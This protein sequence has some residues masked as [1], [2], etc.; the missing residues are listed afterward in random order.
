MNAFTNLSAIKEWH[1]CLNGWHKLLVNLDKCAADTEPLSMQTILD[2]NGLED[3][4]WAIRAIGATEYDA[5][6]F[7]VNITGQ[8]I[9]SI[10]DDPTIALAFKSARAFAV[11]EIAR[12]ELVAAVDPLVAIPLEANAQYFMAR[13][14]KLC[15]E[16]QIATAC[17]SILVTIR[18]GFY[19]L[20]N[21]LFGKERFIP[22][23][24]TALYEGIRDEFVRR[25]CT[26]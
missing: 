7:A 16:E 4:I 2:S 6:L 11:G 25:F 10:Y 17:F 9:A 14:V 22:W 1:P 23:K 15:A 21:Q 3:A 19:S 13:A 8:A 20:P 18:N 5:R 26:P 24:D 12:G